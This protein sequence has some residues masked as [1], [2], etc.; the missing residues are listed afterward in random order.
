MIVQMSGLGQEHVGRFGN[1]IFAYFFLKVVEAELGCEVRTPPWLGETLFA[2]PPTAPLLPPDAGITF[3][4]QG[5]P[6]RITFIHPVR[7]SAGPRSELDAIADFQR[8]GCAVLEIE[9]SYQYHLATCARYRDLHRATFQLNPLLQAQRD[10]ALQRIGLGD[11]PL[12]CAHIRRG[13]YLR[14]ENQHPLFWSVGIE[15]I[16]RTLR[17]LHASSLREPMLYIASDDLPYCRDVFKAM[18]QPIVTAEDLF[19]G[20]DAQTALMS[21]FM[22][23]MCADVLLAANSSLSV[24]ASTMN[25]RASLFMRPCPREDRLI[26]FVPWHSHVLLARHPYQVN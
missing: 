19:T 26:P 5:D 6:P 14:F 21:D 12:V 20:L 7:R 22:A 13:D 1:Q 11:R 15:A 9:G 16:T 25:D 17:D 10:Q 23:M 4:G 24:A 18:Q 2:L 3:E 8:R